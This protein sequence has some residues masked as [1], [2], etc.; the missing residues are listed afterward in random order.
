[1]NINDG[2]IGDVVNYDDYSE[3]IRSFAVSDKDPTNTMVTFQFNGG[4]ID[5]QQSKAY[6]WEIGYGNYVD[7]YDFYVDFLQ[8]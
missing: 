5:A 3:S 7:R 4:N 1:M 2:T 8:I 6:H